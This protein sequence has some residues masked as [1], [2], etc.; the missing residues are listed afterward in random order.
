GLWSRHLSKR[1]PIFLHLEA[2][3]A[4]PEV[5]TPAE[6]RGARHLLA[7]VRLAAQ[8]KFRTVAMAK[9]QGYTRGSAM[10]YIGNPGGHSPFRHFDKQ[11]LFYDGHTLDP[12]HPESLIYWMRKHGRP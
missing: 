7:E 1:D 5:V 2:Q 10:N 12:R 4:S 9:A 3:L 11:S 8:E 6:R